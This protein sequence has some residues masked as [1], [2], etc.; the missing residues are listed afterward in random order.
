MKKIPIFRKPVIFAFLISISYWLYLLLTTRMGIVWDAADYEALGK[1]LTEQGWVEF[2]RSGLHREPFYPALVAF[3]M[4][5]GGVLGISYQLTQAAV[6]LFLLFLTQLLALRILRLLKI[7]D[8]VCFFTVLYLG[9]SPAL[10]NSALSLYSEIATYP[11]ILAIMLLLYRSW[12]SFFEAKPRIIRF[13]IGAGLLFALMLLNKGIFELLTPVFFFFLLV[14]ALLTGERKVIARVFT[15]S[16]AALAVFYS[17]AVSYKSVNKIFNGRFAVTE[18]GAWMF[19]GSTAQKT[20]ALTCRRS[21]AALVSVPGKG[22]CESFFTREECEPWSFQSADAFGLL[23][24]NELS[25]GG[26]G[27][28]ELDKSLISLSMRKI[29]QNPLQYIL[30]TVLE[31]AKMFFWESTQIGFVAYP[32]PLARLFTWT[33]LKNGLRLGVSFLTIFSLAYLAAL[34]RR[35]K[36]NALRTENPL[37]FL[38]LCLLFILTFIGSY[39]IVHIIT[40]YALPIAPLYLIVIAY[41][42]HKLFFSRTAANKQI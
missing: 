13:A 3:S 27:S 9:I 20:Q 34:I 30:F 1:M 28:A 21:L 31:G 7:N 26:T 36:K 4:K 37:L 41:V 17:L 11:F 22:V 14:L 15:Y 29:T 38:C 10:V 12:L 16:L 6:Q 32:S 40:R 23:K 24:V 33:P 25:G 2:F 39:S 18:R 19:Y 35:Q 5:L 42:L 8:L